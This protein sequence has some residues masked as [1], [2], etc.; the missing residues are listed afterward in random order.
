[1]SDKVDY[2]KKLFAKDHFCCSFSM[3]IKVIFLMLIVFWDSA[4]QDGL[5]ESGDEGKV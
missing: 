1:M 4:A 5:A 3:L 2:M